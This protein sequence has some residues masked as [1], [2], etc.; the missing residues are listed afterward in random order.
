MSYF[1]LVYK[2]AHLAAFRAHVEALHGAEFKTVFDRYVFRRHG[3]GWMYSQFNVI[4]TCVGR[5]GGCRRGGC[6]R[7]SDAG[8][9]AEEYD[10]KGHT[11]LS[12]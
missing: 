3:G 1:P 5:G 4:C 9:R 7:C 6:R 8:D 2:R 11:E 12:R 10:P